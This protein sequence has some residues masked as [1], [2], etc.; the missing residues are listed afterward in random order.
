[1]KRIFDIVFSL[2]FLTMF[3]PFGILISIIIILESKG[4]VFYRQERVGQFNVSFY[5]FKFRTMR[6]DA[7]KT[8]RLT[9]GMKDPR[10]TIS[11]YYLRKLKMDE[12]PQF[13][14]V[15]FGD[16]SIVGPRPEVN[17]FVELYNEEQLQVLNV[18]PGITDYASL[19]YFNENE[20][21]GNS[22]N[23]NRTYIEEVMP[24]K[25][26]LNQK[27]IQN[28]SLTEDFKIMWLTFL[29]IIK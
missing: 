9:V 17:E 13:L 29:K 2:F 6:K 4:G 22:S 1:M 3:L 16:M 25:L 23:P 7:D 19:A 11:G 20:I 8:G 26:K 10:I 27:Y 5:L 28:P 12:F 24:A 21:L 14:N 18:K 15:L